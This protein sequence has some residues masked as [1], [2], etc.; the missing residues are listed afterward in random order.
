VINSHNIAEFLKQSGE[1]YHNFAADLMEISSLEDSL[2]EMHKTLGQY[3]N[4]S[5]EHT[6]WEEQNMEG[7]KSQWN[8]MLQFAA[9]P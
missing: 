2:G 8:Q 7:M 6:L 9:K 3:I 4:L 5:N 1:A